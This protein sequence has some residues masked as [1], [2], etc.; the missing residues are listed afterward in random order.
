[1]IVQKDGAR[2][3]P[4]KHSARDAQLVSI[5]MNLE[6]QLAKIAH[7][8]GQT[9]NENGQYCAQNVERDKVNKCTERP[10]V[11]SARQE[12]TRIR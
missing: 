6:R 11:I 4:V 7:L 9:V 1:M 2:E 3:S 10:S 12:G 8:A 5:M